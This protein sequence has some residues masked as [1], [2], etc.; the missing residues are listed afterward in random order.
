MM[1][2]DTLYGGGCIAWCW[3]IHC[4]MLGDTLYDAGRHTVWWGMH[5]CI[6]C[7]VGAGAGR[8]MMY[9]VCWEIHCMMLGDT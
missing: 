1:L 8:Y 7:M 3:E 5:V 9:T 4:M 2:G 6:H